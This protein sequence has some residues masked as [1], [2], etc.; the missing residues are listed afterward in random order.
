MFFTVRLTPVRTVVS[1]E[2]GCFARHLA[3]PGAS[4]RVVFGGPDA[5]I[6]L[7][8]PA[9]LTIRVVIADDNLLVREGVARVLEGV[10]DVKVVGVA[11][12]YDGL[13]ELIGEQ[14]PD[15]V[16][17]DIRMPPSHGMEGLSVS[18]RLHDSDPATGVIVLSQ[19]ADPQYALALLKR[20]SARRGYL[21]KDRIGNR[22]ELANAIKQVAAGG[23]V[24]D[25]QVVET[26][27]EAQRADEHSPLQSLTPRER[28]VLALVA[29]GKSN[30]A[31]ALSLVISKRAV[32]R[33][34]GAIFD[35]LNLPDEAAASRRVAATLVFLAERRGEAGDRITLDG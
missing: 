33:H 30:A 4:G 25:P 28:E 19:Y 7:D 1:T 27:V 13:L 15:V 29:S 24:I 23:S 26:L 18:D 21:L 10:R 9:A 22:E 2:P 31:I 12:D 32:E 20:G 11:D 14:K 6:A 5:C 34:I 35:K 16:L 8:Q 3:A 17:T